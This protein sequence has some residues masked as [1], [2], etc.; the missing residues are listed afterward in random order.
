MLSSLL[1]APVPP[2]LFSRAPW[3]HVSEALQGDVDVC[4]AAVGSGGAGA[5]RFCAEPLQSGGLRAHVFALLR[6]R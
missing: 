6:A 3:Q 5:L 2:N 4:L 1:R